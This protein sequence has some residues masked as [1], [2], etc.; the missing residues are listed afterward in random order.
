MKNQFDILQ[1][2]SCLN[3]EMEKMN[4]LDPFSNKICPYLRE[5][6]LVK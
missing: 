6:A 5:L 1:I 2:W 3:Q 4:S